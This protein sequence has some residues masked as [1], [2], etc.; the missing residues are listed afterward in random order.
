MSEEQK[1]E[2]HSLKIAEDPTEPLP[3]SDNP[4][5]RLNSRQRKFLKNYLEQSMTAT[6]AY[7]DAYKCKSET[8]NANAPRLLV[9]ASITAAVDAY[10]E[11]EAIATKRAL[12]G[13]SIEAAEALGKALES[14]DINAVIRAAKDILDRTGHKP[15]DE[16]D[17]NVKDDLNITLT[18]PEDWDIDSIV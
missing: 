13:K 14:S 6:D 3:L 4:P 8:A 7:V 18:L 1:I 11:L 17:M 15:K 12:H 9:K 16:V 10:Q 2:A 5:K